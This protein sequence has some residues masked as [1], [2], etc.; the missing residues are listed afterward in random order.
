VKLVSKI[1]ILSSLA[2]FVNSGWS[3]KPN[4][5][6]TEKQERHFVSIPDFLN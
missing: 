6:V 4:P 2:L 1:V 5:V 3:V